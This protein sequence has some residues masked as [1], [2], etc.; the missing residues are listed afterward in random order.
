AWHLST[1]VWDILFQ[2]LFDELLNPPSNV[3][4]PTPEVITP[5]AEVVAPEPAA[6]T[7]LPSS[8]TVDQDV[9]SPIKSQTTLETQSLVNPN[10]VE[11]DNHELDVAHM[12]NDQFFGIPIPENNS[13]AS[14]SLDVIPTIVHIATPNSEHVTK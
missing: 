14:S 13:K 7:G 1:T 2:P 11:E 10:D 4:C 9:P 6:L 12:N 5:V 3:D 8:T